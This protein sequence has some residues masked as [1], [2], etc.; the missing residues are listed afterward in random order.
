MSEIKNRPESR[1]RKL[2]HSTIL[3][4]DRRFH[5]DAVFDRIHL[6]R[7][8]LVV[9]AAVKEQAA[10][11]ARSY[12]GEWLGRGPRMKEATLIAEFN[13]GEPVPEIAERRQSTVRAIETRL[14][15]L[16]LLK[17]DRWTT[18]ITATSGISPNK[19]KRKK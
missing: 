17:P 3:L 8:L 4:A 5:P 13:L 19:G 14:A 10:H 1:R 16:S 2:S 11:A 7:A 6:N 15:H 9:I 18:Y 12:Q